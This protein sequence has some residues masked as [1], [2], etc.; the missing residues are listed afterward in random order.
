MPLASANSITPTTGSAAWQLWIDTGG[1]FTDCIATDPQGNTRRLKVLSSSV[2]RGRVLHQLNQT[3]LYVDVAWPVDIDI[4]KGFLLRVVGTPRTASI[5][6]VDLT[7]N[8]IFLTNPLTPVPSG[9]FFELTTQE[10]VPVL[11]AR[12][13]TRTP[14]GKEFPPLEVKLGSTRGTNSFL[15]KRGL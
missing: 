7:A 12:F 3:T 10:E 11:A 6:R 5:Q 8:L 15:K 4:F 1:T 14:L 13:L 2:L 9:C